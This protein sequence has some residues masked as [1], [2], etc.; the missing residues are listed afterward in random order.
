MAQAT[1]IPKAKA[2]AKK[3]GARAAKE[4][5]SPVGVAANAA[6]AGK[7]AVAGTRA[8][9]KAVS[10]AVSHART[11][12]IV[13]GSAAVGIAGGLVASRRRRGGRRAWGKR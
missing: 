3:V 1:K 4:A 9:G 6:L 7:A 2:K 11:P 13:G 10:S 8:A 5:T 12:L